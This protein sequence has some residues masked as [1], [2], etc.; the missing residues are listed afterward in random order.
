M[1]SRMTGAE[2]LEEVEWL[3]D[4]GVHPLMVAQMLGR[5]V[6]GIDRTARRLGNKRVSQVFTRWHSAERLRKATAA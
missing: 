6:S 3:L 4:G 2:L 1:T 5:T